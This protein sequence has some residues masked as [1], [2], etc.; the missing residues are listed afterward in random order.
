MPDG[1]PELLAIN[2]SPG[3]IPKMPVDVAEL[4]IAGI[5]GDGHDHAKHVTPERAISL[6]DA[7]ILDDLR[8]EGFDVVPGAV[9]E[10]LTFRGLAT[11]AMAPGDRILFEGGVEI[12]LLEPRGPCFVLD[13][14][15]PTL[16]KAIVGRCGWMA[17]VTRPGTLRHGAG[18]TVQ[19]ASL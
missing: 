9:G 8:A 6:I 18:V 19:A 16:K 5:T 7:E 4:T 17:R 1:D 11:R 2:I 15:D 3:G 14:I 10:N 12:E 13:A